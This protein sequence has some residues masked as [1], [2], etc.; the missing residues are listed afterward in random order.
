MKKY[1]I[2]FLLLLCLRGFLFA[3]IG[4]AQQN[5]NEDDEDTYT[6]RIVI[7]FSYDLVQNT[8]GDFPITKENEII[9]TP[10]EKFNI[11]AR[12]YNIIELQQLH[13]VKDTE[14]N[15]NGRYPM[16][17]FA[18]TTLDKNRNDELISVLEADKDIL[19]AELEVIHKTSLIPNDPMHIQQWALEKIQAYNA[20]DIQPG[21]SEYIIIGIV[22]SG[23]KWNHPDLQANMWINEAELPG[24]TIN[25]EN[26][27]I[28]GG[29][30]IDNDGNGYV[31][32]VLGWDFYSVAGG[33]QDNNPFQNLE[34]SDHGTHVAGCAAAVGMNSIGVIGPAFN[35]KILATKHSPYNVS[36][37]SIY[38]GYNGIYYM[39]DTG[40]HIINCSWGGLGGANLAN[41]AVS[42][43]KSQGSLVVV[44]A[45]N[46]D[47]SGNPYNMDDTS[48]YP[49]C[50]TDAFT[51]AATTSIDIRTSWSNYGNA[52]DISSPGQSI[53][54]PTFSS[55]GANNYGSKS[56][57]SMSSPI[58]AG[59]AALIL[60][61]NPALTVEELSDILRWGGDP[62][63]HLN[64]PIFI[65]KM[66]SGRVNALNSVNMAF[67]ANYDLVA[68][69]ITSSTNL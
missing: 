16:N 49:A 58:V 12:D 39:A 6:G 23:V 33:G 61:Q 62:I 64:L 38:N 32:D 67:P 17:V 42:Y 25:W 28:T 11:I 55:A 47:I 40:A 41:L 68:R 15:Q 65:G 29:D 18:I 10:F 9:K 21:G 43:A 20:W 37:T 1:L 59:V 24:I 35:V 27:T 51:V 53:L 22:D 3:Q 14:W 46:G 50:A 4:I 66:G 56:G 8:R 44:S 30:G 36:S 31:D 26:G 13:R 52:V 34:G 69:T 2:R 19:F 7:C 54:A 5:A 60:S 45:G 48:Y 57:T 63:D